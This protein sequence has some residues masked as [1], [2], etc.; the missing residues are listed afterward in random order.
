M[1]DDYTEEVERGFNVLVKVWPTWF[2]NPRATDLKWD[3][4][5]GFVGDPDFVFRKYVT[6]KDSQGHTA[7]YGNAIVTPAH[8]WAVSRP[9]DDDR[10][11]QEQ[12]L[13]DAW[14]ARIKRAREEYEA[15]H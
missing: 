3:E 6:M 1:S 15:T 12:A 9:F 14:Q 13:T 10:R 11:E 5:I 7:K 8:G 4:I 2:M